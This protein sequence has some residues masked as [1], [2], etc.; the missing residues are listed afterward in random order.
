MLN[1]SA[2]FASSSSSGISSLGVNLKAFIFQLVTFLLVLLILR[3]W[4]F[5]KLVATLESRRDAL[6]RSL[7][8]AKETEE[9]LKAAEEKADKLLHKA[10]ARADASL[11]DAAKKA[12]GVI[13]SA[14]SSA[15]ERAGQV[16]KEAK[17]HLD[18]ERER[19]HQELR[20]ELADLVV[21][22]TEKVLRQKLNDKS[23][24]ALI[25]T[26]LKELKS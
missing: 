17:A 23:D 16:I 15:T 8:Q 25:E 4:V 26:S 22:T 24:Q 12:E 7:L 3:R 5:P 1:P 14:E 21:Q 10:R 6:E 11:A 9:A 18:Q 13:A 19:L 2:Q 20:G